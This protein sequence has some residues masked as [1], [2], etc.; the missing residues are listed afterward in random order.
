MGFTEQILKILE[1]NLEHFRAFWET[2]LESERAKKK[3]RNIFR[4]EKFQDY[5]W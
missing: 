3:P 4:T 5:F 2:L 1:D